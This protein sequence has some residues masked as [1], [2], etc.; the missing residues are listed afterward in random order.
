MRVKRSSDR[1][2]VETAASFWPV[3]Q[4]YFII[5]ACTATRNVVRS[6]RPRVE[7]GAGLGRAVSREVARSAQI[8]QVLSHMGRRSTV[9]IRVTFRLMNYQRMYFLN[10]VLHINLWIACLRC[11]FKCL[12]NIFLD[13]SIC[14]NK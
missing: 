4:T 14:H 2:E 10:I 1:E 5:H 3:G 9:Y 8:N 6:L 13:I 11:F 12:K 7:V